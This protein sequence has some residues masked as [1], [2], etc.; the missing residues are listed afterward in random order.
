MLCQQCQKRVANVHYTQI[1]NG[2]KVELHLCEQC[3]N[4]KGQLGIG[5]QL[6][7]GD[8]LWGLHSLGGNINYQQPEKPEEV[9]CPVCNMSFGEFRKTGR[10]GCSNCYSVFRDDL[11]P[12]LKRIHGSTEH[13]GKTPAKA[14][15]SKKT[16]N[17]L[18]KL[19]NELSEA[20]SS[21]EYEKAALLRD[22]IRELEGTANPDGGV[23]DG[24]K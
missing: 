7:L 19:K 21:E 3:V 2:K 13:K 16:V 18:E 1:V 10:L 12:I 20:I 5:S 6:N 17:E 4:E 22:K 11:N 14:E 24:A 9:R 23:Q 15:Q 8:F